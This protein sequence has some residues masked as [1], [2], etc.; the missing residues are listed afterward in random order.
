MLLVPSD[1]VLHAAAEPAARGNRLQCFADDVVD[2]VADEGQRVH[3]S[4]E[5]PAIPSVA[6]VHDVACT[7]G[8]LGGGIRHAGRDEPCEVGLYLI[9]DVVGMRVVGPVA[10]LRRHDAVEDVVAGCLVG[11]P[12]RVAGVGEGH[13]HRVGRCIETQTGHDLEECEVHIQVVIEAGGVVIVPLDAA[14]I[15]AD[16]HTVG[17]AFAPV[18]ELGGA[19]IGA[20]DELSGPSAA[21]LVEQFVAR[22][23]LALPR[24]L[25]A[26]CGPGECGEEHD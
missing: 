23:F 4:H 15:P 12:Q 20:S 17:D 19:A 21:N 16:G 2:V 6:V 9:V 11:M 18:A 8:Y 25:L 26:G 14:G 22:D 5:D 13:G 7:V 10:R 1:D 3:G 24:C